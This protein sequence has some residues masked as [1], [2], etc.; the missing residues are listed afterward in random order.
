MAKVKIE[1]PKEFSF[2]TEIPTTS[3]LIKSSVRAEETALLYKTANQSGRKTT[4]F[5]VEI[6]SGIEPTDFRKIEPWPRNLHIESII[7]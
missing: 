2:K 5:P 6:T 7:T 1:L 4:L 3:V